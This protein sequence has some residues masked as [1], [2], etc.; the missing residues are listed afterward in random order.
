MPRR[1][2]C[3]WATSYP[4]KGPR[5]AR[6]GADRCPLRCRLLGGQADVERPDRR[7]R[8]MSI[9]SNLIQEWSPS[10]LLRWAMPAQ[11]L[12]VRQLRQKIEAD[13]ECPQRSWRSSLPIAVRHPSEIGRSHNVS[14]LIPSIDAVLL[15]LL[16][17]PLEFGWGSRSMPAVLLFE[18]FLELLEFCRDLHGITGSTWRPD[19]PIGS[20]SR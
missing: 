4:R 20:S 14:C 19:S 1:R 6:S 15:E 5:L 17:Q 16:I 12:R 8:F 18:K 13:P 11:Y 7:A 9:R 3:V 2:L 10:P